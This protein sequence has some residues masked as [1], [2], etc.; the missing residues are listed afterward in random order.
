MMTQVIPSMIPVTSTCGVS[1]D[2]SDDEKDDD[3]PPSTIL[4][5]RSSFAMNSVRVPQ[6]YYSHKSKP[7]SGAMQSLCRLSSVGGGVFLR[8]SHISGASRAS[9]YFRPPGIQLCS[10]QD[11][12]S[13]SDDMKEP[14]GTIRGWSEKSRGTT[15]N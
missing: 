6:A 3:S 12:D 4:Y 9:A 2:M 10:A 8:S 11:S 13:E 1:S 15:I 7:A 5:T 14:Q